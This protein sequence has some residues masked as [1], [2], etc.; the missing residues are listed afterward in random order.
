MSLHDK[1]LRENLRVMA[2]GGKLAQ[3]LT[4]PHHVGAEIDLEFQASY[5]AAWRTFSKIFLLGSLAAVVSAGY[6]KQTGGDLGL[7]LFFA[8]FGVA[9]A[10]F[11]E[12]MS[13]TVASRS[14]TETH[15]ALRSIPSRVPVS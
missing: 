9:G 3:D 2:Q 11:S 6:Q 4:G 7:P 14:L 10:F 15:P 1:A 8:G 12:V 5:N 13:K